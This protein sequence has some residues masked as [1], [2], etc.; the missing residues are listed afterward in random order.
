VASEVVQVTRESLTRAESIRRPNR[1]LRGGLVLLGALAVAGIV[2]HFWT[3]P[4]LRTGLNQLLQFVDATKGM[5][6]YLAAIAIFLVTLEVRYK[7]RKAMRAVHE[8]RA[9]AHLIDMHQLNKDPERAGS[10]EGPRMESGRAMTV[11]E[12]GYYLDYCTELLSII[13]KIGQLYV[14]DFP[15]ATAQGAVDQFENLAT[16]LSSKIWQ[17]IMIL[18][19]IQ[20]DTG[21]ACA[22]EMGSASQAKSEPVACRACGAYSPRRPHRPLLS[23]CWVGFLSRA[24]IGLEVPSFLTP[25]RLPAPDR[26]APPAASRPRPSPSSPCLPRRSC[27]RRD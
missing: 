22:G 25:R 23:C 12:V 4:D 7:R 15:D 18:E 14:Q 9:M 1:F 27:G 24:M 10:Q 2:Q 13:S 17:K 16:G 6:A 5:A 20:A 11:A 26:H 19:R 21:V 8:L 3:S